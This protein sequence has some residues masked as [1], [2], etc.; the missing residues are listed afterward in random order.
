LALE[1]IKYNTNLSGNN[2]AKTLKLKI[3]GFRRFLF[4]FVILF[5]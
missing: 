1:Y 2:L 4:R 5:F 3:D